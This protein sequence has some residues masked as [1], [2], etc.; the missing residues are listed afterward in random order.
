ML[1]RVK[2]P[3]ILAPCP[4]VRALNLMSGAA[5]VV[6]SQ[7]GC[8][9]HGNTVRRNHGAPALSVII[10]L[11]AVPRA[12]LCLLRGWQLAWTTRRPCVLHA[13]ARG[14]FPCGHS[15]RLRIA[16][17][18]IRTT[19]IKRCNRPQTGD[20][21]A[22]DGPGCGRR[23]GVVPRARELR[24]MAQG[25]GRYSDAMSGRCTGEQPV[26]SE[27]MWRGWGGNQAS[28]GVRLAGPVGRL[29]TGVAGHS[30]PSEPA[31]D[32]RSYGSGAPRIAW[33]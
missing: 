29:A 20:M 7:F 6:G 23:S 8:F 16:L 3:A 24:Q 9:S 19:E 28:N 1:W 17:S 21:R 12:S 25:A 13:P 30:C 15:E 32:A 2:R 4:M 14:P 5:T 11:R 27:R 33:Q 22:T 26:K 18:W 31:A 10:E